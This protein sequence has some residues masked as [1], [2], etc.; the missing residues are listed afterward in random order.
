MSENKPSSS[1]YK[2]RKGQVRSSS[3]KDFKEKISSTNADSHLEQDAVE[4]P[5]R[6]VRKP[7]KT[8]MHLVSEK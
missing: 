6:P 3:K 1:E 2:I 8:S 4:I 5:I 7:R